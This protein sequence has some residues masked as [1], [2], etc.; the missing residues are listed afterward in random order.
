VLVAGSNGEERVRADRFLIATGASPAVPEIP[1][2]AETPYWTSTEAL[3][4]ERVPRHLVVIGGSA[5]AVELGQAFRRLGA[6]VTIVARSTLLSREDADLGRGLRAVFEREGI[7]VLTHTVPSAVA[8]DGAFR[9]TLPKAILE[10]DALLVATG[11]RPNT[12]DLGLE[13]AEVEVDRAGAVVV[14]EHMQT[15]ATHVYAAGDCTSQPQYVYVAAAAGTRAAV[16]MTGGDARLDLTAMPAVIFTDPQVA[17]VGLTLEQAKRAGY[18]AEAR[19]LTLDHLPRAL[20]NFETAGFIK[21]V[22]E[23][24][25]GRLLGAQVLADSAGEIIQT[26]ALALVGRMTVSALADQLFPYLTMVEGL[27]LCAQTFTKD[28]NMLSCCAG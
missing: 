5:V 11:R 4:A 21:L 13:H 25:S 10:A 27:K 1:G 9:I 28:I 26:A 7:R 2:L 19:T 24:G 22:A 23:H 8:R 12:A 16:N 20:V 14:D 6:E 3:V 17:A 18:D 15:S